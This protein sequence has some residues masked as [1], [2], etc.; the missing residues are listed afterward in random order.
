VDIG[1]GDAARSGVEVAMT[2]LVASGLLL[3]VAL[4]APLDAKGPTVRIEL[5]APALGAPMASND[6]G[7]RD[8]DVWSGPGTSSRSAGVTVAGTEGFIA[9]WKAGAVA[10]PPPGSVRYDALFYA[11]CAEPGPGCDHPTLVYVVTYAVDTV[12]GRGYVYFPGHNETLYAINGVS[13]YRGPDVEGRWF[14]ATTAW[15]DFVR[16]L[17]ASRRTSG[18]AIAPGR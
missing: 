13:I 4:A 9:N 17:I 8:F 18:A 14:Q 6:P 2:R 16:P 7:V 1:P 11:G 12:S 15:D 10:A 3:V 5:R